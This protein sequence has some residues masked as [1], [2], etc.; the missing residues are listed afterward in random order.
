M[1]IIQSL[2]T[3]PAMIVSGPN[4]TE[5]IQ[6]HNIE[7]NCAAHGYPPPKF[8]WSFG[9][10]EAKPLTGDTRMV[11]LPGGSLLIQNVRMGDAGVYRCVASNNAGTDTSE[12]LVRVKGKINDFQR[13]KAIIYISSLQLLP[14]RN[15]LTKSISSPL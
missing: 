4:D 11:V 8:V 10:Q 14:E 12:A 3:V 7:L 1:L 6:G 15:T 9:L 5:V 13:S 2:S